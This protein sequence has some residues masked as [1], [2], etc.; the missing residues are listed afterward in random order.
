MSRICFNFITDL[1]VQGMP[2]PKDVIVVEIVRQKDVANG[3]PEANAAAP[4]ADAPAAD[5]PA[6]A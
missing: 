3:A 6:A 4:A 2:R 5:A 1:V